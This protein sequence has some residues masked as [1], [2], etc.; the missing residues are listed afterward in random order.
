MKKFIVV[1]AV[2]AVAASVWAVG[3]SSTDSPD[4]AT[5]PAEINGESAGVTVS[6]TGHVSGEPDTLTIRFGV[7]VVRPDIDGAVAEGAST[8]E[9]VVTALEAEGV[10]EEQIQT[11][12]YT[13]GPNFKQQDGESV[14]D[15]Y[16]VAYE[17]SAAT[18]DL[19]NAGSLID[20]VVGDGGEIR[21]AGVSFSLEDNEELLAAAREEAWADAHGK[22]SQLAE[23]ADL[24]IGAAIAVDET[25][26]VPFN[27]YS[28]LEQA[29]FDADAALA[30]GELTT[31]V[32]IT[33]RFALTG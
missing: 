32:T 13:I 8:A 30:P 27:E 33:A 7:D 15:G 6:G 16:R 28:A 19:E 22:A 14:P 9:G 23:L 12:N 3:C 31:T 18:D 29:A 21:V 1:A 17:I 2:A 5:A 4:S 24:S 20:S 25:A 10:S 11:Q 26:A